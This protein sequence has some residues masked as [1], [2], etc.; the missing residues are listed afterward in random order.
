M[1]KNNIIVFIVVCLALLLFYRYNN[2]QKSSQQKIENDLFILQEWTGE[3]MGTTYSIKTYIPALF[4]SNLFTNLGV[5]LDS[6]SQAIKNR[7]KRN[8]SKNVYL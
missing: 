1:K 2:L 3:T 7:L 5:T 6:L 8:Q 4:Q